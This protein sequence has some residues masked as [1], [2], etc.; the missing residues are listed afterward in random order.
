VDTFLHNKVLYRLRRQLK[1]REAQVAA[2]DRRLSFWALFGGLL[3]RVMVADDNL[4][5]QEVE[6]MRRVLA[7]RSDLDAE[8][9]ELVTSVVSEESLKGLDRYR[10][11]QGFLE[12][13]T[14]EE[15]RMLVSCLFDVATADHDLPAEEHEE[16]RGIAYGLGLSHRQFIEAKLPFTARLK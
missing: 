3:G 9:S 6:A 14:P 10:L 12:L 16:I 1:Q 11:V 15:R 8:H 13:S 5:E 2:D 7:A 4:H